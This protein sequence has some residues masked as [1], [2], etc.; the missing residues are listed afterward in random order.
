MGDRTIQE[1]LGQYE[2]CSSPYRDPSIRCL[3]SNSAEEEGEQIR[4]V[5]KG[6]GSVTGTRSV[7][8]SDT[9]GDNDW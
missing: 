9:K 2:E 6:S 5:P 8:V 4:G 7:S 3:D 1:T